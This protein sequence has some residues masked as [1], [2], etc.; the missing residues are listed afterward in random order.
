VR[1]NQHVLVGKIVEASFRAEGH[2]PCPYGHAVVFPDCEFAGAAPPGADV[3]LIFSA[4]SLGQI[5]KRTRRVLAQCP[6]AGGEVRL[7]RQV[8]DAIQ[9]GLS[10]AFQLLPVLFR[11]VEEQEAGLHRLTDE[12]LRILELL[13][14]H[15]R[16]AIKG[17]AGSG[18]TILATAQAQRSAR[19]GKAVLLV[20]YNRSLARALQHRVPDDLRPNITINTFHGI[21]ASFC[22]RAG[23]PFGPPSVG[24]Q[25]FWE[26]QAP[27]LL[28]QA[29]D[30][31]PERFD[32]VVVDE[33]QDFRSQWWLPLEMLNRDE[34]SGPL[35]VFYD[36]AQNLF[37]G[38]D[39]SLPSLGKPYSLPTNCRNTR[40]I[41]ETC[42]RVGNIQVPT[43]PEA[44]EGVDTLVEIVPDGSRRAKVARRY[45]A[46]W[47]TQGKL[48]P[49][50]VAILSPFVQARSSM[51]SVTELCGKPICCDLQRWQEDEGVLL[52]TIRS[53]KGLGADAVVVTDVPDPSATDQF[54]ATDLYVACS[55][56]KHI[57]VV[58][59]TE[60]GLAQHVT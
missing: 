55:R 43:R 6:G 51:A 31:V 4:S 5:G 20:C 11:K 24:D 48:R 7:D 42:S 58:L 59:G 30:A 22:D 29:L 9:L 40:R 38:A 52:T 19:Q 57:L 8:M 44:P 17:V 15:P 12:Q 50:Q 54:T 49:S 28:L 45:V 26:T 60:P 16:A 39:W 34:D 56:A 13:G 3:E 27:D 53:F 1:R 47:I 46:E 14:D 33:A 41:A 36:P 10:P 23:V 32:A 25:E 21:C 37:A 2:L 18:K 35:Y